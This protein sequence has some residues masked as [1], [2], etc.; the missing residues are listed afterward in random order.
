MITDQEYKNLVN[1]LSKNNELLSGNFFSFNQTNN[2][3]IETNETNQYIGRI[4]HIVEN[5]KNNFLNR[6]KSKK[7]FE[8]Y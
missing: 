5:L 1:K 4:I 6:Y 8:H 2:E 7:A 3:I